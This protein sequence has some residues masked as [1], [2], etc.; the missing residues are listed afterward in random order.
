MFIFNDIKR[1][2]KIEIKTIND[3]N[4]QI[5]KLQ[6]NKELIDKYNFILIPDYKNLITPQ[7]L[8]FMFK[9]PKSNKF[10]NY[11]KFKLK[12]IYKHDIHSVIDAGEQIEH[13]KIT[14][15]Y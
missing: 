4:T 13:G 8:V 14:K 7:D 2:G 10:V 15:K 11:L 5:S 9:D 3:Y 12:A 1:N 6:G